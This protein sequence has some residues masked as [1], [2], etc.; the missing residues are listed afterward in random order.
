MTLGKLE[1]LCAVDTTGLEER[2]RPLH[3]PRQHRLVAIVPILM[4]DKA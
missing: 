4:Y 3:Q 1:N 2:M